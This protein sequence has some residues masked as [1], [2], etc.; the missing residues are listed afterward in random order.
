MSGI[1]ETDTP[2]VFAVTAGNW[3]LVTKEGMFGSF[4][5]WLLDFRSSS[6]QP[7][8]TKI[9]SIPD[10]DNLN[11]MATIPGSP[12]IILLADSGKG[13]VWTLDIETKR[14]IITIQEPSFQPTSVRFGINGINTYGDNFYFTSSGQGIYGSIPINDQGLPTEPV[15]EIA[16]INTTE[17][18]IYD[19][20]AMD[21]KGDAFI[22]THPDRVERVPLS[23]E[24]SVLVKG[25]LPTSLAG[26]TSAVFGR[27]SVKEESTLYV[28]AGGI[29]NASG[30]IWG[31]QVLAVDNAL[32]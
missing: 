13:A 4:S 6:D 17:G 18:T 22:A 27:G 16:R 12:N 26:P 21:L 31:G 19:D 15:K 20:F 8:V 9:A 24:Q 11:G 32:F 14:S 5:V 25:V 10:T 2:D 28:S 1:T 3:T 23:G 29:Y 7:V 30:S